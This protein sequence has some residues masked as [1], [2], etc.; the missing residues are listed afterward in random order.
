MRRFSLLI[1]LIIAVSAIMA[2]P[3][4]K[5]FWKVL[6]LTDGTSVYA[7]LL[8]D[9]GFHFWRDADG[10]KYVAATDSTYRAFSDT[11]ASTCAKAAVTRN[12][13]LRE[14]QYTRLTAAKVKSSYIGSRKGIIILVNFADSAFKKEHDNAL[15]QKI[16]NKENYTSSD[17]FLGSVSDYFK[18][19]SGGLF[20]LTFDIA[21]PYTLQHN[22]SYY[23]KNDANGNDMHPEEMIVEACNAAY[24]SGF[25]FS[26]YDWNGD[27]ECEQVF[28]LYA[29]LGEANGGVDS[30]IWPHEYKLQYALGYSLKL[31]NTYVDTYACGCELQPKCYIIENNKWKVKETKID[32]I[33]TICHEFSHCLGFMDMYDV[34]NGTNYGMGRW[35]LMDVGSYNGPGYNGMQPAGYTSYERWVAGW[36]EPTVITNGDVVTN[37]AALSAGGSSYIIY[38]DNDSNEYYLLENRQKV[39]WDG[40]LSGQGLLIIHVDYDESLWMNNCPNSV[41]G[42]SS[43]Y[44]RYY[45]LMNTHQRCTPIPADE[46]QSLYS[47]VS[48]VYPYGVLDSLTN[49][50]MPAATVYNVNTDGSNYMNKPIRNIKQG[51]DGIISF[52]VGYPEMTAIGSI[53]SQSEDFANARIYSMSGQYLG[54]DLSVLPHGIYVRA[55]KKV[56]K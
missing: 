20:N 27:G 3:A 43:L 2:I 9:E 34:V 41:F 22:Y 14:S 15:Y 5:G 35:D 29:G 56:A 6:L 39:A 24:A 8:G 44:Y 13:A 12:A 18:A 51:S 7:E 16:A 55:G 33:G 28:V 26:Q 36:L 54:K 50:S 10:N 45:G 49:N 38:N 31:G 40:S 1:C 23:G 48:D 19:Q 25:D 46:T 30:T 42:T 47:E 32:G 11:E 4:K 21:G 53:P 37:M 17:G 52:V